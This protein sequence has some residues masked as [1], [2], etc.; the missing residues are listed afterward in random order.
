M[1]LTDRA[2]RRIVEAVEGRLEPDEH[3]RVSAMCTVVRSGV[4]PVLLGPIAQAFTNRPHYIALTDRRLLLLRPTLSGKDEELV[5]A[6]P[7]E[8]AEVVSAKDGLV[9]TKI[10]LRRATGDE[11]RLEFAPGWRKD[12]TTIRGALRSR[13]ET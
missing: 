5:F 9:Q 3:I 6:D 11:V 7:L 1:G 4:L 10:V 13:A 2:R 12:A 8:T